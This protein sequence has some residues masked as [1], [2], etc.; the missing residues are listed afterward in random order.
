MLRGRGLFR[1]WGGDQAWGCV[2]ARMVREAAWRD[3]RAVDRG[4]WWRGQVSAMGANDFL[5]V[6]R[7]QCP[8]RRLP[9]PSDDA[10]VNS[11]GR[12]RPSRNDEPT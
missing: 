8:E 9:R 4:R 5:V 7:L 2:N 3:G 1:E 6:I 11:G 12:L 10:A